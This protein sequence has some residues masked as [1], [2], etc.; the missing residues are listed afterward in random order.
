MFDRL[1]DNLKRIFSS[2]LLPIVSVYIALFLILVIRMFNLQIIESE[3]YEDK[4][5]A[6]DEK[7]RDIQST[8]GNIYD[9]NGK[10]LASNVLSYSVTIEDTGTFSSNEEKNAMI[11]NMISIIH[12]N[13]D[14]LDIDF[15]IEINKKGELVFNV[16]KSSEL[17]FKRDAYFA[18]SVDELTDKQKNATAEEVFN[19]LRTDTSPNG[20]K[21][22]IDESYSL[23]E[24]LDIMKVRYT[25][26]INS[27]TKYIPIKIANDVKNTTVVAIKENSAEMPGV[28]IEET[29]TRLYYDSKYFSN[30]IGYT[31]PVSSDKLEDIKEQY[32][33]YNYTVS[34]QIGKSGI[35][36][37]MEETLRGTKGSE[38]L[39]IDSNSRIAE[40]KD[41]VNPTAGNDI[42]LTIDSDLQKACYEIL[43]KKLAG[44]LISKI[45]NS[46][47]AGTKGES[48]SDIKIPIYDVYNAII[49]NNVVDI[50][51]FNTKNASKTEKNIY[52]KH[53]ARKKSVMSQL[54]NYIRLGFSKTGNDLS[55]EYDAYVD[56]IY[57]ML[58][59]KNMLL[60]DKIDTTDATYK[61]YKDDKLSLSKFL[62]YAIVNSWIDFNALGIGDNLYTT[63]EL[64]EIL[65]TYIFDE[66]KE[67][68]T[69]DKLIYK[70]MIYNY[71]ISGTEI[72]LV[73]IEQEI[74]SS[75]ES[76]VS[77]LI[78]GTLSP[79]SFIIGKITKLQLTP[80]MLALDPCSGSIVITD[81]N[82]GDVKAYV[83][84]PT[85]D[86]NN[87]ANEINSEYYNKV[88]SN[89]SYPLM[90]RPSMQK[91]A[92]GSTFKMVTSAA[93]LEE[94]GILSY[95]TEKIKDKHTFT[96]LVPSPKC[97]SKSSHGNIDVTDA[98]KYSCNYFY[99][100]IGYRLGLSSNKVL[101]HDKGLNTLKKYAEMFGLSD[102]SGIEL[103]EASPQIS[104][105][106]CVRS[107]IGQGT[108]SYTPAQLARYV[109]T[110]ANSGTCYNLTLIDKTVTSTDKAKTNNKATVKNEVDFSSSTWNYIQ[111]GMRKVISGG[112]VDYL[113]E[114]LNVDVAG[115]TGTA[116]ESV[117][118]PNHA[119]FV[120]YAPYSNPEISVTT[121]IPNGYTSGNAAELARDIYM[122][123]YDKDARKK[124]LNSKVTKPENQSN[125]FSD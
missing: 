90:N 86:N 37:S 50:S 107:A 120:S 15:C 69:F 5:I 82:T 46:T 42:Y 66:L 76:T 91:T 40:I 14:E 48:A 111:S 19:Y 13:E 18:K 4:T 89:N 115:K 53:V 105:Y 117:Y 97:W 2:R 43:E 104:D 38:T 67:N 41:V 65:R 7:Q 32:P 96:E 123:Y 30:I 22:D 99:Y 80:A 116:Q 108:N 56:Y 57:T 124:L 81:V 83:T 17:R 21:F 25:M 1:V 95:P 79:Y 49:S 109:T 100:E 101:N 114:K 85:Y 113:F 61:Q 52:K 106:D 55:D 98:L 70:Y 122:Y 11:H 74:V 12:R 51:R 112:S 63:S 47:D 39:V 118:K 64:F 60:S 26:T 73:L 102:T 24:A 77:S 87:F 31:G 59:E 58:T 103:S 93:A 72:C 33:D 44:I 78:N 9:V 71:T 94:T 34:D 88:L 125:A 119:L 68:S 29:T 121:V 8:R 6:T 10:I 75:N 3:T 54:K 20:P 84:Y 27:Y 35:E 16:D 62:E 36:L 92:P 28:K 45:N 110:I 23:E